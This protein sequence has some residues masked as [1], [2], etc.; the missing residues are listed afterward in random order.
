MTYFWGIAS[1]IAQLNLSVSKPALYELA[2]IFS[3]VFKAA[4]NLLQLVSVS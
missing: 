2:H 1:Q 3:S 4:E